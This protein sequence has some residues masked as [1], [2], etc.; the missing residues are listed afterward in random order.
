MPRSTMS[1]SIHGSS[2]PLRTPADVSS[3]EPLDLAGGYSW[4]RQT[5]FKTL[6][7]P[8]PQNVKSSRRREGDAGV[9]SKI[10]R[11]FADFAV[12]LYDDCESLCISF[13]SRVAGSHRVKSA[14]SNVGET[15]SSPRKLYFPGGTAQEAWRFSRRHVLCNHCY[16]T[17]ILFSGRSPCFG[18]YTRSP[19][20]WRRDYEKVA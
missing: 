7:D 9:I 18:A 19:G 10:E 6:P 13:D 8:A 16:A 15:S 11:C 17:K 5:V 14:I 20:Q 12:Q 1:G 3:L 4:E 2:I